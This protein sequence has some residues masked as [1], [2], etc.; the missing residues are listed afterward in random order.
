MRILA[1]LLIILSTSC[2]TTTCNEF[3]GYI[4]FDWKTQEARRNFEGRNP[5]SSVT[6]ECKLSSTYSI[7]YRHTSHIRDGVPFNNRHED[8]MDSLGIEWRFLSW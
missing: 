4:S 3:N 6:F 2:T 5:M 8:Y 1:C 7:H